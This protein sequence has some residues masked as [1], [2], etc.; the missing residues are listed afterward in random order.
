MLYRFMLN[1]TIRLSLTSHRYS[2][3]CPL[4]CTNITLFTFSG[5]NDERLAC[6]I[7]PAMEPTRSEGALVAGT[8]EFPELMM[9]TLE[10]SQPAASTNEGRHLMPLIGYATILS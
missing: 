4:L 7:N 9:T 8:Q 3:K 6:R 1:T 5:A 10:T 2:T